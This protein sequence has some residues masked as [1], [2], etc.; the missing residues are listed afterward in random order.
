MLIHYQGD[1]QIFLKVTTLAAGTSLTDSQILA[2]AQMADSKL[3]TLKLQLFKGTALY[4]CPTGLRKC[5][6]QDGFIC[7]TYTDFT[8][9]F[10]HTQIVVPGTLKYTVLQEV[11]NHLG[12]FGA[13]K[14]LERLKT[15]C[16]W[17]GCEQDTVQWVKQ[18]KAVPEA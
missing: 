16:Y 7:R 5:F 11:H 12:H 10:E 6:L 15:R 18:C 4:D 13:K 14:T 17:P 9:Q 3:A 1:L 8:T 2:K